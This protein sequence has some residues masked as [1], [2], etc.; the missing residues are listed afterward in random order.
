MN[1]PRKYVSG[2]L[3]SLENGAA[4]TREGFKFAIVDVVANDKALDDFACSNLE[5]RAGP[6][7][8][9]CCEHHGASTG[10]DQSAQQGPFWR[11][12]WQI[13]VVFC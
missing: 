3:F 7:L 5:G 4:L 10:G 9:G 8:V 12:K 1:V 6:E 2:R 11:D 13:C